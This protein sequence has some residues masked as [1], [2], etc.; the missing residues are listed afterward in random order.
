ML[1]RTAD[2]LYWLAR[3]MERA[4]Y[5]ARLLQVA[6]H[7]SAL[8]VDASHGSEWE[9]AIVAAGC[10]E[11]Y[12]EKHARAD[13]AT[14]I[15]FLAFDRDNSSSIVNCI[16]TAR[17]NARAVRTALTADMWEAVNA[18][19]Q[20]LSSYRADA[21]D[22]DH[23]AE[24]LD[25]VK[26]RVGLFHGV[27]SNNMLRRDG[28]HF[29]RVGQFLERA[30]NTARLLDVKYHVKLAQVSDVGGVV[31]Y[32]QWLA[33]LRVVSARRAYRVLFK[34][35]VE[36]ARVAELLITS[37]VFPRSL[38]FCYQM[39]TQH[40]DAIESQDPRLAAEAKRQAN[41]LYADLR[42]ANVDTVI[43]KGL[44]EYLTQLIERTAELGA[45][46]ARG[47]LF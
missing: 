3:Y 24:F 25:W 44:H 19:W 26:A 4:D 46:I 5:L 42:Y 33:I 47:H 39:I 12:F 11:G 29:T 10:R 41:S 6:G 43:E 9:S 23:L 45:Q 28:F 16:E 32:Y 17:R 1:A 30:D 40:L 22:A 37:S 21:M 15:Q 38:T 8:R 31:D 35:V 2:N 7:M 13:E 27:C 20:E 34:G 36:P 18:S 14:V